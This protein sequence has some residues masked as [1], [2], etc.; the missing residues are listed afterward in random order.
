VGYWALLTFVPVPGVGAGNYAEGMNLTNYIDRM[1]LPGRKYDG[2]HD[3]E[4]IL[5]TIPAIATALLGI[6]SGRWLSGSA[7]PSR[8]ALGLLAG[9]AVLLGLGW[10]WHLQFPVIKKL[11]TSSFVLVAGG[12]SAILLGLFYDI[13][14]VAGFKFWTR[15]FVWV[16]ANPI[17]LYLFW[18]LGFFRIVSERLVGPVPET[19]SWLPAAVNFG[20]VLLVARFLYR[21]QIFLRA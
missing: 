14:E 10:A 11:W 16:G 18:G 2:D 17:T 9:G 12:W 4:G 7:S 6:L 21:K 15:P 3:P 13:V 20:L 1:W 5:S 8:K 19:L